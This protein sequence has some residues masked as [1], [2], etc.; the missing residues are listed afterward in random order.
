MLIPS[1]CSP[2]SLPNSIDKAVTFLET[3]LPTLTNPYAVTMTSY[4]LANE[5][6]LN[7][8]I[9][10]N[11]ISPGL[12]VR[13]YFSHFRQ[14]PFILVGRPNNKSVFVHVLLRAV[15]LAST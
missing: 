7:R 14:I 8:K 5:K 10:L 12:V 4:A 2:Q 11:F 15:P 6:K 9:L 3:K 1:S 13:Q